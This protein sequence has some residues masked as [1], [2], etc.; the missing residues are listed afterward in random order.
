LRV[1]ECVPNVSEGLDAALLDACVQAIENAG[2]T[3]AH[4]TSD[5]DHHRSV[6]TF[7]GTRAHVLEAALALA[8]VTTGRIDLR[9]HRG[10]HPRIGALDVLPFVPFGTATI[11]DA[12]ALAREAASTI[13]DALGVPSFFY[14]AANERGRTLPDVRAGG[15][16]GLISR[17]DPFDAG[18]TPHPSAGA[19]AIGARLPLVAFNLFLATQD[20]AAGRAI[21]RALRERD[22]GLRTL[23]VLALRLG[24]GRV[25]ISCNLTDV[26]ATPL[27]R[28]VG[29][30]RKLAADAGTHV[31]RTELIGLVPRR[32]L[33][34]V[35]ADALGIEVNAMKTQ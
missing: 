26:A 11:D 17:A 23:R 2:A 27:H 24:D 29:L 10:V 31:V 14:G 8:R 30:V 6:F 16:E 4:R 28:V 3:L 35:A 19:I 9:D 21:A 33:A 12:V 13:W 22:G 1:F 25:Q 34:E 5:G 32:A 18:D 20:M 15:F 7:F